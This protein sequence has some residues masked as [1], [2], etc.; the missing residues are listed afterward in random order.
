[1][2]ALRAFLNPRSGG[3]SWQ[4]AHAD[5]GYLTVTLGRVMEVRDR[6]PGETY[7]RGEAALLRA[8]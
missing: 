6:P 4:K 1:M 2:E 5:V 7:P 3:Y 8:S